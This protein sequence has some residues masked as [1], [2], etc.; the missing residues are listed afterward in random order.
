MVAHRPLPTHTEFAAYRADKAAEAKMETGRRLFHS[1]KRY[2]GRDL[3]TDR[4]TALEIRERQLHDEWSGS[5]RKYPC[6][7]PYALRGIGLPQ[8]IDIV[9]YRWGEGRLDR[10]PFEIATRCRKCGNCLKHRQKIWTARAIDELKASRRTW[11]GT[12]TIRPDDRFKA[13]IAADLLAKKRG[14]DEW[15]ALPRDTK[16]SYLV[17]VLGQDVTKWLKRV[18]KAS[19]VPLRY[20]LVVEA[21]KDGF[22]HFHC[23]IHEPA[24]PVTERTLASNWRLGFSQFR[25]VK[26]DT[27]ASYYACKYL[28]KDALTRVR[29]SK[30]YGRAQL[31]SALTEAAHKAAD[32]AKIAGIQS[33]FPSGSPVL[34]ARAGEGETGIIG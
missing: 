23:F 4:R 33:A 6:E 5:S 30:S 3:V 13:R 2:P 24:M 25:L 21:H 22:P 11:F 32:A 28:A 9:K 16:F 14:H 15:S 10:V 17:K 29:A 31:M 1:P 27:R 20:L 34:S 12:L 8:S 7:R 19:G 18:R 26:E